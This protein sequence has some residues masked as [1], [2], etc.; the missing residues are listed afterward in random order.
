MD[1]E[2]R[3]GTDGQRKERSETLFCDRVLSRWRVRTFTAK[4]EDHLLAR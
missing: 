3:T 1:G 2:I 4:Y